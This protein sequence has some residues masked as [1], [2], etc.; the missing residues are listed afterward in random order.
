MERSSSSAAAL[1]AAT[2]T[3]RPGDR[4]RVYYLYDAARRDA[5]ALARFT[6]ARDARR[7]ADVFESLGGR[8]E[9]RSREEAGGERAPGSWFVEY[10]T[11]SR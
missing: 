7:G 6:N 3:A 9:V 4:R 5:L 2:A 8:V 1:A 10:V 11:R